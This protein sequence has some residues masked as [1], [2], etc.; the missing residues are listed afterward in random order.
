[1]L[2]SVPY[3]NVPALS[4]KSRV[5]PAPTENFNVVLLLRPPSPIEINGTSV[6]LAV[7]R[8]IVKLPLLIKLTVCLDNGLATLVIGPTPNEIGA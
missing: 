2:G 1:M 4:C 7:S 6:F 5:A 3:R 8:I